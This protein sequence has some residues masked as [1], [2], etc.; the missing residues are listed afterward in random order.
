MHH[1]T[2][3]CLHFNQLTLLHQVTSVNLFR[4]PGMV[5]CGLKHVGI[6]GVILLYKC[7]MSNFGHFV[8]LMS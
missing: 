6:L 4:F 5:H 8:G 2:T 7:L 1:S 3:K